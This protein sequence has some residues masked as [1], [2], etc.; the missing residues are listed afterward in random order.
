[1]GTGRVGACML[2]VMLACAA[3]PRPVTDLDT[4]AGA[5]ALDTSYRVKDRVT[6]PAR[7]AREYVLPIGE[8]RPRHADEQGI[9]YASPNGLIERA[10][11]SK[12]VVGGGLHVAL[13]SERPYE[14]PTLYVDLGDGNLKKIPL[15][16]SVARRYGETLVFAVNGEELLP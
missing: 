12:R 6:V 7:E 16:E 14:H 4:I 1:M 9:F 5:R 15:P 11:F 3:P 2:L 8:Y 13:G 10:G